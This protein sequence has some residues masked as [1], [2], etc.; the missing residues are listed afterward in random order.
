MPTC[1]GSRSIDTERC[2]LAGIVASP[3]K[4]SSSATPRC[5]ATSRAVL[6]VAV[7]VR[8]R[9][10]CTPMR[11]RSICTRRGGGDTAHLDPG[12]PPFLSFPA[13][14]SPCRCAG[15]R[16]GSCVTTE[17]G[18]GPHQCRRRPLGA[19]GQPGRGCQ[20][21]WPKPQPVPQGIASAH[22]PWLPEP[23]RKQDQDQGIAQVASHCPLSMWSS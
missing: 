2:R 20:G 17:R 21:P 13:P 9:K 23:E 12:P 15:S 14:S 5:W 3:L 19:A 10:Q 16:A 18:S 4:S 11:S 6:R 22:A 8:P 7:A 1:S